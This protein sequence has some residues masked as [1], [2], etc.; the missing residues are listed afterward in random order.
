M[1]GLLVALLLAVV[2]V[3][4]AYGYGVR[5]SG[6]PQQAIGAY[7]DALRQANYAAAYGL[8]SPAAQAQI[9]RAQYVTD[10]QAR[11]AFYGRVTTCQARLVGADGRFIFW[12]QPTL[13][14]YTLTLERAGVAHAHI[15]PGSASGQV[16]LTPNGASWRVSEVAT[17]L[18][19]IDLDPLT[20]VGDFCQAL[21]ARDY[22]RAYGDLSPAFQ[23]E[24]GSASAFARAFGAAG[25]VTQCVEQL[26]TYKVAKDDRS[27]S[28]AISLSVTGALPGDSKTTVAFTI[29]AT[30]TLVRTAQGWRVDG[31]TPGAPTPQG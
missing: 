24:Q 29:P 5:Q 11:D 18:L 16:A 12:R 4:V 28:L 30:M 7:C 21:I 15:A 31:L 17:S 6:A 2:G 1:I 3:G 26:A 9:T 10:G 27:A 25:R 20:T 19:G 22:A 23:H 14:V 13:V 8:L